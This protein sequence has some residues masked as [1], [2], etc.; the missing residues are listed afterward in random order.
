[1]TKAKY[2][3]EKAKKEILEFA[4]FEF[5]NIESE[6]VR[7]GE[8][9]A[10]DG[11]HTTASFLDFSKYK[12]FNPLESVLGIEVVTSTE[13]N[14]IAVFSKS[15]GNEPTRTLLENLPMEDIVSICET[16]KEILFVLVTGHN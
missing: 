6:L 15:G 5:K 16:L 3:Y 8:W 13:N 1:M 10:F 2:I 4:L 7:R 9:K 12:A 14:E 11:V